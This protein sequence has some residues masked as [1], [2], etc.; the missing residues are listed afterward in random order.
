MLFSVD[1][2]KDV[3]ELHVVVG[4]LDLVVRFGIFVECHLADAIVRH[5]LC[6]VGIQLLLGDEL[7]L[8]RDGPEIKLS[9]F[10]RRSIKR[11]S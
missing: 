1:L 10:K 6:Q 11:Q 8:A 7:S 4:I 2:E 5:N 3:H 9:G